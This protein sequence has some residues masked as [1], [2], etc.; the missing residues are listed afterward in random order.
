MVVPLKAI[1]EERYVGCIDFDCD[2]NCIQDLT[3]SA[4]SISQLLPNSKVKLRDK[5][6]LSDL[7]ASPTQV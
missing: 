2:I 1:V 7:G 6:V 5:V 3:D 4:K